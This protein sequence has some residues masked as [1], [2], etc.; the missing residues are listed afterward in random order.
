[1]C[2]HGWA[3]VQ[4]KGKCRALIHRSSQLCSLLSIEKL[5]DFEEVV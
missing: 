2:E 3:L 5:L 1:M 4:F